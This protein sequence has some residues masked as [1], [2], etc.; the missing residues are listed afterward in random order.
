MVEC[1]LTNAVL[2]G[3]TETVLIDTWWNV[4]QDHEQTHGIKNWF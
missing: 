1:E 4:N 2:G 3:Y